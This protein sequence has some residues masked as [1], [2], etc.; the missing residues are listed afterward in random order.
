MYTKIRFGGGNLLP[1]VYS[2][3]EVT[4]V[5]AQPKAI[6]A[7]NKATAALPGLLPALPS[8]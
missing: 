8:P 4:F 6:L 7:I 5:W 3:L 1:P 2:C